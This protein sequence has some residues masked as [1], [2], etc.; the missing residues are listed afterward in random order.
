MKCSL[1]TLALTL[2]GVVGSMRT[3][4]AQLQLCSFDENGNG[5]IFKSPNPGA[6]LPDP[7][8]GGKPALTYFITRIFNSTVGNGDILVLDASGAI[9][10]GVRATD[11]AGNLTGGSADRLIF[12]STDHDGDLADT[13]LPANFLST[14]YEVV[15]EIDGKFVI[16]SGAAYYLGISGTDPSSVPEP[17]SAAILAG[18]GISGA[19]FF[20]CRKSRLRK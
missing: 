2:A 16:G 18:S 1:V 6:L 5:T 12:Y 4:S 15:T 10:D 19:G 3:A 14:P 13:G 8:N 7:S 9:S 17:S 20:V 11:A